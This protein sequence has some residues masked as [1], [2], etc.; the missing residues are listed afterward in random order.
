[1]IQEMEYAIF[2]LAFASLVRRFCANGWPPHFESGYFQ[3]I[4]EI[5]VLR[6]QVIVLRMIVCQ[7][8][9]CILYYL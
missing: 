6:K 3:K 4:I 8:K 7:P 9:F 5:R 1:M 2:Y